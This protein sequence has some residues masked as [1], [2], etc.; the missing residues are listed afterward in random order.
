[1]KKHFYHIT[2]LLAFAITLIISGC[3]TPQK[4]QITPKIKTPDAIVNIKPVQKGPIEV[5]IASLQELDALFDKYQ[6]SS[7]SWE[8]GK[9]K[10]PRITFEKVTDNW[11][12]D[13]KNL[14]VETKK[15]FFFRLMA[16][17]ILMANENIIRERETV[18]HDPLNSP[19]LK[20]IALKYRLIKNKKNRITTTMRQTLLNK[21]DIL[22]PSLALAQAAEESGWGTSR[23]AKEGNAFFGQWDFSGNGMKPKQQRKAL[24]NYGVARFDSPLAS[25]EGYMLNLNTNNAYNKLRTLRAQLRAEN[26]TISGLKLAGTLNKYSERGQAYIDGLREMIRYNKL[27]FVDNSYLAD[28]RLI[29]LT[30]G[31]E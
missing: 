23:F 29:H 8:N 4:P 5:S 14:P 15:S 10:L 19:Q 26:E 2:C 22:P 1:M 25:V 13:S 17:L 9:Q 31:K 18:K 24:G 3:S 27:Q 16:P 7:E 11:Q 6:Y 12:K 21:V 30:G 20:K 28:N